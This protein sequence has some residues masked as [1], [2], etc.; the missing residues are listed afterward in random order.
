MNRNAI[1]EPTSSRA[2]ASAIQMLPPRSPLGSTAEGLRCSLTSCAAMLLS[3]SVFS[4]RESLV[5]Y[6]CVAT[7]APRKGKLHAVQCPASEVRDASQRLLNALAA[8]G[9]GTSNR[10]HPP[11]A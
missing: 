5:Q 9:A 11:P 8:G 6:Q 7:R 10:R 3:D 4:R 2:T 1:T